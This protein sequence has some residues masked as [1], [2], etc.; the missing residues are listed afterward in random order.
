M[1][2][3]SS[4]AAPSTQSGEVGRIVTA[5]MAA[6]VLNLLDTPQ[7]LVTVNLPAGSYVVT[8]LLEIDTTGAS[9]FLYFGIQVGSVQTPNFSS[10]AY[11][12]PVGQELS[13]SQVI[14]LTASTTPVSIWVACNFTASTVTYSNG[15]IKA[16]KIA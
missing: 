7:T 12:S 15:V 1:S 16:L 13:G 14:T 9:T 8:G 10:G 2:F 5:T 3:R 6:P 4:L 11:P